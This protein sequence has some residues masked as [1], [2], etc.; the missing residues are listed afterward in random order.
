[1]ADTHGAADAPVIEANVSATT[2]KVSPAVGQHA[3][4]NCFM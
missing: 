3:A 2:K 4:H 1:V